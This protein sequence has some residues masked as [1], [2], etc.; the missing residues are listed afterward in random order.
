MPRTGHLD[1]VA[2]AGANNQHVARQQAQ[3]HLRDAISL[4]AGHHKAKGRSLSELYRRFYFKFDI[5]TMSAQV[6]GR[7]D[8]NKLLEQV[9]TNIE[10]MTDA[11]D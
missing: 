4:W 3:N 10:E 7:P 1:G 9:N 5:D 11:P 8:A 2:R 6:L